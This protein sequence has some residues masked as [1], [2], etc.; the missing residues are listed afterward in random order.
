M[1]EL[2]ER[3]AGVATADFRRRCRRSWTPDEKV[4][5]VREAESGRDPVAVVA[6][7]HG[8]NAN[9]LHLWVSR[10]RQGT[11]CRRRGRRRL[12]EAPAPMTFIDLGVTGAAAVTEPKGGGGIIEIELPGGA[13][14]RV[15][16]AVDGEALRRVLLAVKAAL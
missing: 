6:R 8:M 13:R 16:E 4:A 1:G 2:V 15:C 3:V 9:H 7:R 12:G 11:L 14:V 10:A 5:I